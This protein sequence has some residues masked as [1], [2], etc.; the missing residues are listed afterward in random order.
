M[1]ARQ[2]VGAPGFRPG[3]GEGVPERAQA[4]DRVGPQPVPTRGRGLEEGAGQRDQPAGLGQVVQEAAAA[5]LALAAGLG[6]GRWD[7]AAVAPGGEVAVRVGVA[8]P[9][10]A[11]ATAAAALI[12][13]QP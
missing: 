7:G 10:G 3:G 12:R 4:G 5:G 6:M 9:P 11:A 1:V 2:A 13:P 8:V